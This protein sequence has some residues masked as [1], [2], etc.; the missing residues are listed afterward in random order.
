MVGKEVEVEGMTRPAVLNED[1][2]YFYGNNGKKV[3]MNNHM[4]RAL[5]SMHKNKKEHIQQH[6]SMQQE[7]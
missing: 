3:H 5:Q 4:H 1:G 7:L 2:M 6:S